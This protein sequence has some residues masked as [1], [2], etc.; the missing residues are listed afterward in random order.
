[1]T[2][3]DEMLIE[4]RSFS[5]KYEFELQPAKPYQIENFKNR[6]LENKVDKFAIDQLIDFYKIANGISCVDSLELYACDDIII[7][8]WWKDKVLWFGSRDYY[9]FTYFNSK[10][11]VGDASNISFSKEYEFDDLFS[12]IIKTLRIYED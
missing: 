6:C 3:F 10:F 7:F 4:L 8:E 9:T 11:C 5:K 1:M 12:M 2:S